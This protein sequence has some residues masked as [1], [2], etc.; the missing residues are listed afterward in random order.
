MKYLLSALLLLA[1]MAN[2][3]QEPQDEPEARQV[4]LFILMN[5]ERHKI[6]AY[7]TEY[8]T[9]EG[10]EHAIETAKHGGHTKAVMFCGT[11]MDQDRK[12]LWGVKLR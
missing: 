4:Y 3:G 2:A 11:N 8:D 1:G 12:R 5:G 7:R 10:C 6:Q 9:L